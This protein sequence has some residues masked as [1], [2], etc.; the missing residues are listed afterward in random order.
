MRA[1]P[2]AMRTERCRAR[3]V[4]DRKRGTGSRGCDPA[5]AAGGGRSRCGRAL[6]APARARSVGSRARGGRAGRCRAAGPSFPRGG[7]GCRG[8]AFADAGRAMARTRR[9][10]TCGPR[11]LRGGHS[12]PGARPRARSR[13]LGPADALGPAGDRIPSDGSRERPP[14]CGRERHVGIAPFPGQVTVDDARSRTF[15][16]GGK[17]R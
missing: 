15:T 4:P 14:P 8:A 2:R 17:P 16:G 11:P 1:S 5:P 13:G 10:R 9:A 3:A 7:S 12:A 6:Q